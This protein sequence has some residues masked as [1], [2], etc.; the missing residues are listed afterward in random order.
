M[1]TGLESTLRGVI[2]AGCFLSVEPKHT[3]LRSRH[4][5]ETAVVLHDIGDDITRHAAHAGPGN[6]GVFLRRGRESRQHLDDDEC[7]SHALI[8]YGRTLCDADSG[9]CEKKSI[10]HPDK[11][12]P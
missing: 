1:A 3:V 10:L 8:L 2:R 11:E 4:P 7:A 12:I 6:E 5:D 9:I